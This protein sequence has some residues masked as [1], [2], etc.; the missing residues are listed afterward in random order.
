MLRISCHLFK[1]NAI[2]DMAAK[3][4]A[5]LLRSI[6]LVSYP[7]SH[8]KSNFGLV[9]ILSHFPHNIDQNHPRKYKFQWGYFGYSPIPKTEEMSFLMRFLRTQ[10]NQ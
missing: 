4:T 2:F 8:L 3:G 6:L 9:Q 5:L 7:H 10:P 1:E